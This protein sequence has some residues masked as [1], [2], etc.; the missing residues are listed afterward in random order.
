MDHDVVAFLFGFLVHVCERDNQ[1]ASLPGFTAAQVAPAMHD[2]GFVFLLEVDEKFVR[3]HDHGG[4]VVIGIDA[5][6][7]DRQAGI[8]RNKQPVR[9]VYFGVTRRVEHLLAQEQ[10]DQSAQ[11]VQRCFV[12]SLAGRYTR[13]RSREVGC[14]HEVIAQVTAAPPALIPAEHDRKS[15]ARN[16]PYAGA[17]GL[18]FQGVCASCL[19]M[20]VM[21]RLW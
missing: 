18:V 10:R 16:R 3:V 9:G 19:V 13:E 17:A 6:V 2:T 12:Q 4:P 11:A 7:Q 1:R 14:W 5:E 8:D 15:C 21:R 20:R